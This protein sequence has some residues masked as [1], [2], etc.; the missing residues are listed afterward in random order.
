MEMQGRIF[1]VP[2]GTKAKLIETG[3]FSRRVR[4]TD[5]GSKHFGADGW[6]NMEAVQPDLLAISKAADIKKDDSLINNM[7]SGWHCILVSRGAPIGAL[8]GPLRKGYVEYCTSKDAYDDF[9]E[10]V[11]PVVSTGK[12]VRMIKDK[13]LILVPTNT[14]ATI[15]MKGIAA[16][17]RV[18]E[19]NQCGK[20]GWVYFTCVQGIKP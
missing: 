14:H 10:A 5:G 12:I 4:I 3:M 20:T 2:S 9:M 6:V 1:T 8:S 16:K 15:V 19:G 17:V 7:T 13:R 18:D 11:I